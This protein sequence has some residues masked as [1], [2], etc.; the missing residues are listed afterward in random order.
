M[1]DLVKLAN[2]RDHAISG[3][4]KNVRLSA[5]IS[6]RELARNLGID[7]STLLRWERGERRPTGLA[8]ERWMDELNRLAERKHPRRSQRATAPPQAEGGD[9][10]EARP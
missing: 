3:A 7:A 6:L 10:Q 5:G 1:T 9:R 2:A 4:G 8:A